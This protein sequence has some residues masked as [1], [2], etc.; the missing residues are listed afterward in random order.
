MTPKGWTIT[1]VTAIFASQSD[2]PED[3]KHQQIVV[4]LE[5]SH[6]HVAYYLTELP[7][8][9]QEF[10]QVNLWVPPNQF[11]AGIRTS[12]LHVTPQQVYAA[13]LVYI[14]DLQKWADNQLDSAKILLSK[15]PEYADLLAMEVETVEVSLL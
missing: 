11:A 13:W 2:V 15:M 3:Q 10:I 9:A 4:C 6:P 14:E 1:L 8:A 7:K 5:H 12:H